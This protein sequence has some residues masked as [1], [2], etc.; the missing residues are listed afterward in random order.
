LQGY[1]QRA[2]AQNRQAASAAD[3]LQPFSLA[4]VLYMTCWLHQFAEDA[5]GARATAARMLT[6]G[7]EKGFP[8]FISVATIFLG[9]TQIAHGQAEQAV[10][11]ISQGVADLRSQ[12]ARLGRSYHLALLADACA[13]AGRPEESVTI[14]AEAQTFA[15]ANEEHIWQAEIHR[16]RGESLL[17][18]DPMAVHDAESSFQKA[19]E[20]AHRQQARSLELRAAMSLAR[21]WIG[22]DKTAEAHELLAPLYHGFTEGFQTHDL[23]QAKALLDQ[24]SQMVSGRF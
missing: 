12:G 21:L 20:V 5:E 6:L 2:A 8:G 14:L 7:T 10:I 3:E 24:C 16:L 15:D 11:D 1:P 18:L 22:Q 23:R 4:V 17:Q 13:Q 9:W 19:L